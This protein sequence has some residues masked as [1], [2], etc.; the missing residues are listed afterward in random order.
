[1]LKNLIWLAAGVGIGVAVGFRIS[2]QRNAESLREAQDEMEVFLS[3][4]YVRKIAEIREQYE[5]GS[6]D[7]PA[8]ELIPPVPPVKT[9][10]IP[11]EPVLHVVPEAVQTAMVNYGAV[12]LAPQEALKVYDRQVKDDAV[13]EAE[14]SEDFPLQKTSDLVVESDFVEDE[15][16]QRVFKVPGND[17]VNIID[18]SMFSENPDEYE[19]Y[20]LEYW[21]GNGALTGVT[22]NLF[23][24]DNRDEILGVKGLELMNAGPEALGGSNLYIRHTGLQSVFEIMWNPGSFVPETEDA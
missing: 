22:N 19:E 23:T 24:E 15:A 13:P 18:E 2:Q 5:P 7:I 21:A 8:E 10:D 9:V 20:T 16:P 3:E 6:S 1:M 11:E 17:P 12:P 4:E 14:E